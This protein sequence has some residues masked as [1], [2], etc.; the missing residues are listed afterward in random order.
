MEL[1]LFREGLEDQ[2][3]T[4]EEVER[5]ANEQRDELVAAA[6]RKAVKEEPS[7]SDR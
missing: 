3:L 2:G 5:R 6:E 1:L 4:K 7:T